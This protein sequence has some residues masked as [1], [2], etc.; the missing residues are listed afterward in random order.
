MKKPNKRPVF[1]ILVFL[2]LI[3]LAL[4]A[5]SGNF[6]FALEPDHTHT[7]FQSPDSSHTKE[8][9]PEKR[10]KQGER[11]PVIEYFTATP[12][13]VYLGMEVLL[14]WSVKNATVVGITPN[15]G[16]VKSVSSVTVMP[17][18]T[19]TYTLTALT[20]SKM[21]K[22]EVVVNVS[23]P[24][25]LPPPPPSRSS[26]S[27]ST[28]DL[29]TKTATDKASLLCT[30][31][32]ERRNSAYELLKLPEPFAESSLYTDSKEEWPEF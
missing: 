9:L 23:P 28:L 29:R 2:T 8:S 4:Q 27:R 15:I 21:I 20:N 25:P 13:S 31:S 12:S 32:D 30:D 18:E 17:F 1:P 22:Q 19:T 16:I 3:S 6:A 14:V 24:P 26:S 5:Q 10:Q 11:N 7:S